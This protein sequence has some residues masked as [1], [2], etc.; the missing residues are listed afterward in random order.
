MILGF[1]QFT[2]CCCIFLCFHRFSVTVVLVTI[3][4]LAVLQYNHI[5]PLFL[6]T[7]TNNLI[8]MLTG[9]SFFIIQS[10]IL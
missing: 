10:Y 9:V 5:I 8:N 7:I 1:V 6:Q 4:Y 3:S 2:E